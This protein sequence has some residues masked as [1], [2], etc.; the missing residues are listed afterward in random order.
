MAIDGKK[1]AAFAGGGGHKGPTPSKEEKGEHHD[2]EDRAEHEG[3]HEEGHDDDMQEGGE[4]RFGKLIPLLEEFA[5]EVEACCDEIDGDLLVDM[6][7][8]MPSDEEQILKSGLH[9]LDKK[10]VKA[11]SEA[12]DG[13]ISPEEATEL[14]EHLANEE[15]VSDPDRVAGWLYRISHEV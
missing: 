12:F 2:E 7:A 9:T 13:G 14:A 5:E 8:E 4:G 11:L 3:E 15:I 10:L 6:E 1:L